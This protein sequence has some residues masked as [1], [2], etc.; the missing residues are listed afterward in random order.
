M[1]GLKVPSCNKC[2][3]MGSIPQ[4]VHENPMAEKLSK[5]VRT[6]YMGKRIMEIEKHLEKDME[7]AICKP[8]TAP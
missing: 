4:R 6:G 5:N 3:N 8:I 7:E 1:S 2:H